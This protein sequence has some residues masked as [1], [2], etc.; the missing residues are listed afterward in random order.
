MSLACA[1][2]HVGFL[3]LLFD[4]EGTLKERRRKIRNE[5]NQKRQEKWKRGYVKSR[6]EAL[7]NGM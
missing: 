1:T 3:T 5:T 2:H 6:K 7:Q 4:T